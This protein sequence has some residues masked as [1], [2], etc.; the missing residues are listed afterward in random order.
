MNVVGMIYGTHVDAHVR[1]ED[2][3]IQEQWKH[4]Q[5]RFLLRCCPCE[6]SEPEVL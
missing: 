3:Q 4:D 1:D 5:T 2:T 6:E